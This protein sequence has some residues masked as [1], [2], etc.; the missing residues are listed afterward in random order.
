MVSEERIKEIIME[1]LLP[2]PSA[3]AHPIIAE[4]QSLDPCAITPLDALIKIARW[5][6]ELAAN[7]K[8]TDS[9]G[10]DKDSIR[11]DCQ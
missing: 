2:Q 5:K 10:T 4:L 9:R 8:Q 3:E 1:Q 11:T 6:Q 7:T